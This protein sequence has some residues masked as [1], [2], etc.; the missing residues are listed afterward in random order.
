MNNSTSGQ[1]LSNDSMSLHYGSAKL[2]GFLW[3]DY[4]CLQPLDLSE[5]TSNLTNASFLAKM[6]DH[7]ARDY[8]IAKEKS[9]LEESYKFQKENKC[10]FFQFLSL[11]KGRG[12]G[13][14]SDGI[15]G[16]APQK[17]VVNR[18]KNYI[19]SLFNNGIIT[20]PVLSFSMAS[21]DIDDK[22]YALFGGYNSSQIVGGE[23]GLQTF[24][25]NQ[26]SYK[27]N[28]RNWALDIKDFMYE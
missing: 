25:N 3:K 6:S 5:Q 24:K 8:T 7:E 16:L 11:Y 23:K 1:V 14:E 26:G 21:S 2:T 13:K 20:K 22:P 27:S 18:E 28:M 15:L 4:S 17:S 19:W 9:F 10:S 12:L